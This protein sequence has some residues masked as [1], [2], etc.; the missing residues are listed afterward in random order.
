MDHSPPADTAVTPAESKV[1]VLPTPTVD[2]VLH[3]LDVEIDAIRSEQSRN[4]FNLWAVL[5]AIV[6]LLWLLTGELK[7][8]SVDW[9]SIGRLIVAQ[10]LIIDTLKWL[11]LALHF[12]PSERT[13]ARFQWSHFSFSTTRGLIVIEFF[14]SILIVVIAFFCSLNAVPLV[15][16]AISYIIA[17][18]LMLLLFIGSFT[19][20]FVSSEGFHNKFTYVF[21]FA[22]TIPAIVALAFVVTSVPFPAGSAVALY[23][24]SGL[25]VGLSYL[26]FMFARVLSGSSILPLLL[27]TRRN[28]A[29]G[30]TTLERAAKEV[31]TTLRGMRVVDALTDDFQKVI[32]L[33]DRMDQQTNYALIALNSIEENLPSRDD[34]PEV[35]DKKLAT[36][37]V[38][39]SA[40]VGFLKEY[41]ALNKLHENQVARMGKL[42]GRIMIL[43]E[44][45]GTISE[46]Q[47][48]VNARGKSTMDNYQKVEARRD[49]VFQK[50][51]ALKKL[52]KVE[53][54]DSSTTSVAA[55][56]SDRSKR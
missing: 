7:E 6:G 21:W 56:R 33:L 24:I 35:I 2:D 9:I 47:N 1:S 38:L 25:M 5:A 49:E 19:P 11:Y 39:S 36:I 40:Y 42:M 10:S 46:I 37:E 48:L 44:S 8:A 18:L 20:L 51:E 55:S 12:Q 23:R 28:L 15:L 43:P 34:L 52:L 14:R 45:R 4:G 41:L 13:E 32:S 22:L 29:L 17:A 16:V 31:E 50:I 53:T 54:D 3:L 26:L 30:K 27:K